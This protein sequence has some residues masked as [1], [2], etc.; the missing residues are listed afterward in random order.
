MPDK[1]KHRGKHPSDDRI[2]SAEEVN[3]LRQ[4]VQDLNFLLTRG[5]NTKSALK[6]VGD[7]YRLLQRQRLAL[8]HNACSDQS[9][10]KRKASEVSL[11][12]SKTGIVI[13]GYNY[14]ITLEA[15]FSGAYIFRGREGCYR[16]LSGLHGSYRRVEETIQV[17]ERTAEIF[18][19]I[20]TP[21]LWLFDSPV[22]NSGRLVSLL[23][24]ISRSVGI[25]WQ[26]ELVLNPDREIT[27]LDMA[28]V[29]SDSLILDN[30]SQWINLPDLIIPNLPAKNII[31][32]Y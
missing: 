13:D 28:A 27:L 29:S 8:A 30:C 31:E 18:G 11:A 24:E 17:I 22:S 6:L 21:V 4:A 12:D 19:S 9:L 25:E 1:R 16:D 5:Y 23:R 3:K 7:R 2:F 26:A 15:A 10:Q 14:L 20:Q 32:L